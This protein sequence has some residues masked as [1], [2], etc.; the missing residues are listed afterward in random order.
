MHRGEM[1]YKQSITSN[2][3]TCFLL[4]DIILS[5]SAERRTQS[6][7]TV[8]LRRNFSNGRDYCVSIWSGTA[9]SSYDKKVIEF[10]ES[11]VGISSDDGVA[12]I[13]FSS[14]FKTVLP[15]ECEQII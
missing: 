9:L 6:T 5:C 10:S 15:Q 1:L 4:P 3:R 12:I 2:H 7:E 8:L 11:V 14:F 13:E